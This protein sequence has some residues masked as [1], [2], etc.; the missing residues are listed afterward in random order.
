MLIQA[1]SAE[2]IKL[3]GTFVSIDP[4]RDSEA[5]LSKYTESFGSDIAY[6]RFEGEALE[7]FKTAFGVEVDFY[8]K[9]EGN[10]QHYQVNHS[11]TAFL[12]NPEGKI[13]VMFDAVRDAASVAKLF[14]E[15]RALFL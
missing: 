6:L 4:D 10:L 12:I 14:K 15:N 8:T 3:N 1:A 11:T 13:K 7:Q 5:A 9:N 2:E